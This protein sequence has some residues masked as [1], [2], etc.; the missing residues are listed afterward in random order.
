MGCNNRLC[1]ETQLGVR[2]SA[3]QGHCQPLPI[4]PPSG[5]G[6][7]CHTWVVAVTLNSSITTTTAADHGF[8]LHKCGGTRGPCSPTL[9]GHMWTNTNSSNNN[10]SGLPSRNAVC[11]NWQDMMPSNTNGTPPALICASHLQT[12][13]RSLI[14]T[15]RLGTTETHTQLYN[16]CVH[17]GAQWTSCSPVLQATSLSAASASIVLHAIAHEDV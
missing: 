9:H 11:S 17:A 5:G 1:R 10:D 12:P 16:H 3:P 4:M 7:N 2:N 6:F 8:G 14:Q 13:A 15:Q